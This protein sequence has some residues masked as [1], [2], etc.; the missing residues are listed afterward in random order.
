MKFVRQFN[1]YITAIFFAT[2]I[3]IIASSYYTFKEV[4]GIQHQRQQEALVPL[5][6]LINSEV[7]RPLSVAHFMAND[8][9]MINY[10]QKNQIDKKELLGYLLR[11]A[12]NYKMLTFIALEQHG[13]M[14]DSNNKETMLDEKSAEWYHR[15]KVINK[16]Q[17]ADIGNLDNPPLYFDVKIFNENKEF[18]GFIGAAIDL[19]YF[20]DKFTAY[21]ELFGFEIYFVDQDNNIILS[22]DHLMKTESHH[23]KNEI[24]N[25]SSL[26]WFQRFNS[27][28]QTNNDIFFDDETLVT[29]MP[30]QALD[31]KLYV[32]SPSS[33]QQQALGLLF[34]RKFAV[35]AF[36]III[37]SL[38][39][40]RCVSYFKTVLIKDSKI[41]FLTKLPNRSFIYWE[42]G[43]LQKEYENASIVIADIDHFK[44]INDQ[45]GHLVGDNVLQTQANKMASSLR[46]MDLIA[47]WG[48]E[49]FVMILPNTTK[50]QAFDICERIRQDIAKLSF[51]SDDGKS[52]TTTTSFGISQT[53]LKNSG[54]DAIIAEADKALY[55]AK[56]N[57]RNQIATF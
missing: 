27:K 21:N 42:F 12:T 36:V 35:F 56:S 26:P 11:L 37:I 23:R 8:H 22:S 34:F 4:V 16:D 32:A 7:I 47:R 41:D 18:L 45:Y 57:G 25:I 13:F 14:L 30:I 44:Q 55:M 54:L 38:I 43:R 1:H 9:L 52:F 39:F 20:A 50:E 5:F 2:I 3:L 31:W 46:E 29:Q 24:V 19:N 40:I 49:E 33:F 17:I 48:G 6:S 53:T 51:E 28:N 10:I 15:L